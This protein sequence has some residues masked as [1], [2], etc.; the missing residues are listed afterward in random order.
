M[1]ISFFLSFFLLLF[2]L[3]FVFIQ[4]LFRFFIFFCLYFFLTILSSISSFPVRALQCGGAT[5][6]VEWF[7]PGHYLYLM[8]QTLMGY[9]L[10]IIVIVNSKRTSVSRKICHITHSFQILVVKQLQCLFICNCLI[11]NLL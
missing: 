5:I 3:L 2:L 4:T 1:I 11:I 6:L 10:Y 9:Q 8:M 7:I